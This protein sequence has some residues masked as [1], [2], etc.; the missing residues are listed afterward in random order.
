M[1]HSHDM[2]GNTL[3]DIEHETE[4]FCF[5][6]GDVDS[7]AAWFKAESQHGRL[8]QIQWEKPVELWKDHWDGLLQSHFFQG[9][10][11]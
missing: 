4:T 3:R 8:K 5:L 10:F 11:T 2:A 9:S 7:S 1:A 6:E